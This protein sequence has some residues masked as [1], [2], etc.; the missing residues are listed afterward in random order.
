[1]LYYS[2]VG[3]QAEQG[4][5]PAI[6]PEADLWQF[7]CKRLVLSML[8]ASCYAFRNHDGGISEGIPVDVYPWFCDD[9][10]VRTETDEMFAASA[11]AARKNLPFAI[12]TIIGA[13]GAVPRKSGRMLVSEDGRIWSTIGGHLFED[14]AVQAACHAMQEGRSRR[15][16]VDSGNGSM[17][18]MID[19]VNPVK[20][21]YIIG[22]GNV[23]KALAGL[24]HSIGYELHIFDIR[25]FSCDYAAES[26]VGDTWGG[27]LRG[28]VLDRI[29]CIHRHRA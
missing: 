24:L 4:R 29:V 21:A 7:S 23:G 5:V 19:V 17:E 27:L 25:P 8:S 26:A 13:A 9:R 22:Y 15:I 10:H 12:V 1:M 20:R 6:E 2:Q 28:L 11:E 3:H 14:E 18:L 16:T